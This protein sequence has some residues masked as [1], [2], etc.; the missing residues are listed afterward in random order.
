MPTGVDISANLNQI[1]E[2]IKKACER[3]GRDRS[4]VTLIA[5]SK[6]NPPEAVVQAHDCGACVFGENKVQELS[7]KLDYMDE[8]GVKGLEWHLIGHLQTN[9]VK[10]CIGRVAMI[11][12]VDSLKLA[13]AIDAESLKKGV[14]TPVLIEINIGDEDSKFGVTP[15]EAEPLARQLSELKN[16]RLCGLMTVAPVAICPEDNRFYFRK[17]KELS[18]DIASENIDN[19]SMNVLSMGMTGDFEIAIEE[20]ATHVRVGTGIFGARDYSNKEVIK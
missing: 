4:E 8:H 1:E 20:G 13:S 9:K 10:Y 11:H 5:V 6:M 3:S 17:M 19:I 12:S 14:I 7:S 18:V 2:R 16:L 15:E